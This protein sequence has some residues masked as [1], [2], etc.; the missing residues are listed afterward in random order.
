MNKEYLHIIWIHG[1]YHLDVH[2][3]Y[4]GF[5]VF[6]IAC[7]CHDCDWKLHVLYCEQLVL[8]IPMGYTKRIT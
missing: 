5:T 4:T 7:L 8:K 2:R 1:N 6:A 3:E